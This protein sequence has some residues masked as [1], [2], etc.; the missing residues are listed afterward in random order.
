MSPQ[1][2]PSH[3]DRTGRASS[4]KPQLHRTPT[5][6]RPTPPTRAP[7]PAPHQRF[8][9]PTGVALPS[10][11]GAGSSQTPSAYPP[12]PYF[13]PDLPAP[14]IPIHPR[15]LP[16]VPTRSSLSVRDSPGGN[17]AGGGH[18]R[19]V[20]KG[21]RTNLPLD[22]QAGSSGGPVGRPNRSMSIPGGVRESIRASTLPP[23]LSIPKENEGNVVPDAVTKVDRTHGHQNRH[24]STS[25]TASSKSTGS[26]SIASLSTP[27]ITTTHSAASST[28]SE[29]H[30]DSPSTMSHGPLRRDSMSSIEGKDEIKSEV[31]IVRGR[32]ES[33]ASSA[34]STS[35]TLDHPAGA[36]AS[37]AS[38]HSRDT[39]DDIEAIDLGTRYPYGISQSAQPP[40][41]NLHTSVKAGKGPLLQN[42][43]DMAR[44]K[45]ALPIPVGK[46]EHKVGKFRIKLRLNQPFIVA[47]SPVV[48]RVETTC[49]S[50]HA[51]L[52]E[53]V[54]ELYAYEEVTAD[55][56]TG[57]YL[58]PSSKGLSNTVR[59]IY[60][61]RLVLQDTSHPSDAVLAA[62]PV[63]E[64]GYFVAK[65]GRTL[66]PFAIPLPT[67]LPTSVETRVGHVRYVLSAT[68]MVGC[69]D[70]VEAEFRDPERLVSSK[71]LSVYERWG[72]EEVKK[73]RGMVVVGEARKR[74][75]L[76]GTG[77][78]ECTA[79]STRGII[80][81][82][83]MAYVRVAVRNGTKK[84]VT[85]VRLCLWRRAGLQGEVE[86]EAE[87][88]GKTRSIVDHRCRLVGEWR[89]R[90]SDWRWEPGE[91]REAVLALALPLSSEVSVSVRGTSLLSIRCFLQVALSMPL[92]KD[93][94]VEL[95]VY[96]TH[97]ASWSDVPPVVGHVER[98]TGQ[99]IFMGASILEREMAGM[100]GDKEEDMKGPVAQR[101][102]TQPVHGNGENDDEKEE[103]DTCGT[104]SA[105]EA[106]A[107]S[108]SDLSMVQDGKEG[109]EEE[110]DDDDNEIGQVHVARAVRVERCPQRRVR[111][112]T[113]G[114]V[115]R[116]FYVEGQGKSWG[117][118]EDD[119]S[120]MTPVVMVPGEEKPKGNSGR[121]WSPIGGED[122]SNGGGAVPH[123]R[124]DG[125]G[126]PLGS[127]GF[128][129]GLRELRVLNP[130]D[131]SSLSGTIRSSLDEVIMMDS[132]RDAR[133]SV[134]KETEE[135]HKNQRLLSPQ[136]ALSPL[137]PSSDG[138]E[139]P[140]R[141]D[142]EDPVSGEA[143]AL[144]D[145]MTHELDLDWDRS[146]VAS[147]D[148]E[149]SC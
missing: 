132:G 111:R 7:P 55:T 107:L 26:H 122:D 90:S 15:R 33:L 19:G 62:Q 115:T 68:I 88:R 87:M 21:L 123:D 74:A 96:V 129:G 16:Q 86:R 142:N 56:G 133:T 143:Q 11:P 8:P 22:I 130:D 50:S 58:E 59:P 120:H 147:K 114:E 18:H 40:Q 95:P 137:A 78:L 73:G 121:L 97:P 91:E 65:K 12:I 9:S 145:A 28:L 34:S 54:I 148:K 131:A 38:R 53:M 82:G 81:L 85:G 134:K 67:D 1:S 44:S 83:G 124:R 99:A 14:R 106:R 102:I 75:F 64:G 41:T 103:E 20:S 89:G 119:E 100:L 24:S 138:E 144:I 32:S 66:F 5:G 6:Q 116:S 125:T 105:P 30:L 52:G 79:A 36:P 48:G 109:E 101:G 128:L 135:D 4:S 45:G 113:I 76:G 93:L 104:R 149:M 94:T 63:D 23:P 51:R 31:K 126:S 37:G 98:K 136:V 70:E 60:K 72:S 29:D 49:L 127:V 71:R 61:H 46:D 118:D 80:T 10:L 47:G 43:E 84:R 110:G 141:S 42:E 77:S 2:S 17:G 69:L 117:P 146:T 39:T 13:I 140:M 139:E 27:S 3:M 35:K 92:S 108:Q 25:S 57:N 112:R